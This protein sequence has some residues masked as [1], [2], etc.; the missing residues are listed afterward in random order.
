MVKWVLTSNYNNSWQFLS[1]TYYCIWLWFCTYLNGRLLGAPREYVL[2]C[3]NPG[4]NWGSCCPVSWSL[5]LF[6][7]A[8][9][10][11]CYSLQWL[12]FHAHPSI[13][14]G[15]FNTDVQVKNTAVPHL[16]HTYLYRI[17]ITICFLLYTSSTYFGRSAGSD[18][19]RLL[20]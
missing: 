3:L 20:Q 8:R 2:H 19:S 12:K 6:V 13:L 15:W 9:P 10:A 18:S 4:L 5:F 11:S 1:T 14:A 7:L 17:H 16:I